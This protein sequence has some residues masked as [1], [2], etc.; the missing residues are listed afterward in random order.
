[1]ET[2][3]TVL[4]IWLQVVALTAVVYCHH[5]SYAQTFV[6]AATLNNL[7]ILPNN[8]ILNTLTNTIVPN[9]YGNASGIFLNR[10]F[11]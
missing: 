3:R 8:T 11:G 7:Q 5:R 9:V 1:M 10:T 2:L 6:P 4:F